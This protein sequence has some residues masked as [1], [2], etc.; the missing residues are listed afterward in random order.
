MS[1]KKFA[2]LHNISDSDLKVIMEALQSCCNAIGSNLGERTRRII[3]G[4]FNL[5][6]GHGSCKEIARY[7]GLSHVTIKQGRKDILAHQNTVYSGGQRKQGGGRKSI[8]KIYPQLDDLVKDIVN[9][10][11]Y[12]DPT[13]IICWTP[14]HPKTICEALEKLGIKV[15]R[16]VVRDSLNR[17]GYSLQH[18]RKAEQVGKVHPDTEAQFKYIDACREAHKKS[19]NPIISVDCKAKLSIGNFSTKI[20][21][22]RVAGDP[23][24]TLDHDFAKVKVAPYG[25]H[26]YKAHLGFINLTTSHDTAAFA[27]NSVRVWWNNYG[28]NQYADA[29]ELTLLCDGGGSNGYRSRLWKKD[30]AKLAEEIGRPITVHHYPPGKSKFNPI[31]HLLFPHVH[32]SIASPPLT[33]ECVQQMIKTTKTATGL[34]VECCIDNNEYPLSVS[35]SKSIFDNI[36]IQP[37]ETLGQWNYTIYGFKDR[38]TSE[39]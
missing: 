7:F 2:V 10:R 8:L 28:K 20:P 24:L 27:V 5:L 14:I 21:E 1:A 33:V 3:L 30:L 22:Y 12:G 32:R 34:R 13:N 18:N 6:L 19:N 15:S 38:T 31:E 4:L 23:R 9:N 39:C 25:V 26:D 29:S 16:N 35:V 36:N 37:H 17:L 11:T